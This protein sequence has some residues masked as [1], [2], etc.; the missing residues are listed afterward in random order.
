MLSPLRGF[1]A[2]ETTANAVVAAEDVPTPN[3]RVVA[4]LI[5]LIRANSKQNV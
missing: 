4:M 5:G 1:T 3:S 2:F